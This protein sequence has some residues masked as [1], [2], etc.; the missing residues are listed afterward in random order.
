MIYLNN[1]ATS[2]PKP[3]SVIEAVK[4][5]L[6]V[7][8]HHGV[9]TGF[10]TDIGDHIYECRIA[11]SK[12][13]NIAD[14]MQIILCSGST[15]ALNLVIRGLDLKG[16]HVIIT[17][18]EHNSV[19][20]PLKRLEKEG[21][22]E[23]TIVECDKHANID[24]QNIRSALR[25]NTKLI[26][27]NHCSNVTGAVADIKTIAKIAHENDAYILVD[28]SQSAGNVPIKFDKWDIDFLA[29]TGHK[30]LY[31][32][33]GT[34]GLVLKKGIELEPLKVG[35]TGIHSDNLFQPEGMPLHYEAGTPNNPGIISL[36]AG[37]NWVMETGLDVIADHK[38]K[39]FD[40]IYSE[41]KNIP[42]MI[43]Y[44]LSKKNAYTNFCFNIEGIVPEEV[45]YIL[46]SSFDILVRT[47]LHC[48]P[49][50]LKP[51]GAHPW[52]TVRASFSYFT[53]EKEIS[54]FID[55][56]K[57]IASTRKSKS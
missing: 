33:Q 14:P 51:I 53:S 15:E 44:N 16:K 52:G 43:C 39:L 41:L 9:R 46:D 35:G 23:L 20:R 28:A 25:T 24:P 22:I 50:L 26:A 42:G 27:I 8:A 3:Q 47:G 38:K 11:L 7:P 19:I 12:I 56:V 40:I 37:V 32:I 17:S 36:L 18:L 10:K 57:Q 2:F 5:C 21:E 54:I 34:G 31:G 6:L 13:F 55:A 48:A 49:L 30:S 4:D 45:G 29:F 1:G